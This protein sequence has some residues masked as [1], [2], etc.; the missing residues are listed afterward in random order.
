MAKKE[1]MAE[2]DG[3]YLIIN[4][5]ARR[6][7][8]LIKT[9]RP[10]IPYAEGNFDPVEVAREEIGL[11]KVIVRNRNEESGELEKLT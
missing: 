5:I 3:K 9:G 11:G 8:Q 4:A 1:T 6:A 10:T 7:K 2:A